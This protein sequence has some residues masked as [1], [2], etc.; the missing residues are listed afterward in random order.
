MADYPAQFIDLMQKQPGP[1]FFWRSPEGDVLMAAGLRWQ[2]M[3]GDPKNWR[4]WA[5]GSCDADP[6]IPVIT[7]S[8]FH[9]VEDRSPDW[10]GFPS[11]QFYQP[12]VA[13]SVREGVVRRWGTE[14]ADGEVYLVSPEAEVFSET[15]LTVRAWDEEGYRERVEGALLPLR[16]GRIDKVVLAR[17]SRVLLSQSFN[18]YQALKAMERQPHAFTVCYSPDGKRFF[19]SATPERL[20][21]ISDGRFETMAL[22]GTLTRQG[23]RAR[24]DLLA[25]AKERAEH[26][27]VVEMIRSAMESF[28][29]DV[30]MHDV[31]VLELPHVTH[32]LTGISGSMRSGCSMRHV[33]AALHPTP[34]VAGTPRE[35]AQEL[36]AAL[37][38]FT[39]GLYAG[40][41]GWFLGE[42]EGDAAVAI[43]SALVNDREA[44]VWAGAGIVRDS[45]PDAEERETRAKLQTMLDILGA[46]S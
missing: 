7:L 36:I 33:I 1:Y 15:G 40:C 17:R 26:T 2:S 28:A 37:E 31:R 22:A 32:I 38:P 46:A 39:R 41:I 34:A 19:L 9:P 13:V 23:D 44:L 43:R 14:E 45:D 25:D 21:R 3:P 16:E 27:Y 35:K 42:R 6:E 24:Q 12:Q 5:E 30:A 29:T 18:P 8:F 11:A 20:G 10:T 4:R